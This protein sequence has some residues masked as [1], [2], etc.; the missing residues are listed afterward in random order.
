MGGVKGGSPA[1]LGPEQ[2]LGGGCKERGSG[3]LKPPSEPDW[4]ESG[5]A[6][7]GARREPGE[8]SMGWSNRGILPV[9]T[10]LEEQS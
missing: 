10:G 1:E 6:W 4:G 9:G 5:G 7:E 3:G 8:A 2:R